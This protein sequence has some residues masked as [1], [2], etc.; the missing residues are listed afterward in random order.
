MWARDIA[1][2]VDQNV[3]VMYR[4]TEVKAYTYFVFSVSY[5]SHP[6]YIEHRFNEST[7]KS[8]SHGVFLFRYAVLT[9]ITLG[10]ESSLVQRRRL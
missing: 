8:S 1:D 2:P 6:I 9:S 3:Y 5:G 10:S 4:L 7:S